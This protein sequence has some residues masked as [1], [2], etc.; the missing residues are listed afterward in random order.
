MFTVSESKKSRKQVKV[1]GT[2]QGVGF[3]PFIY[4]LAQRLKVLGW[5]QN[6]SDG[7][8]IEIEADENTLDSFIKAIKTDAPIAAEVDSIE[9]IELPSI[10]YTDF[11]I[12][13]SPAGTDTKTTIPPDMSICPDCLNDIT[14]PNN[15]RYAYPFTNCTNCGPRFTITKGI[16]YDRPQT[17]MAEFI[18][19][20]DCKAEYENP[21]DR[22]FHAQPNACPI[23]GPHL[24]LSGFDNTDDAQIT[25]KTAELLWAGKIIAIKGLGGYHLACDARNSEAVSTL[26]ERKGRIGKPFAIMCSDIEEVNSICEV[27]KEAEKLLNSIQHPIVLLPRKENSGISESCAPA[28]TKLGIM[29]P[30]TPMHHLLLKESPKS[31]VMTSGNLSEEPIAHIDEDAVKRLSHIADYILSHNRPIY[32][33]CDDSVVRIIDDKPLI[34]RRARGYVPQVIHLSKKL[35]QVLAL[36]S[37]LKN[38]FCITKDKNALISQHIGD[39]ENVSTIEHYKHNIDHF[40]KFFTAKPEVIACDMHPD[41]FSTKTAADFPNLPVVSVQHHHA[42]TASCMAENG[43]DGNVIGISFDGT[44]Y[45]TDGKIWGSEFMIAS[46]K[47]FERFAHLEYIPIP[48]GERAIKYPGRMALSY[49]LNTFGKDLTNI[50]IE[51]LTGLDES[52]ITAVEFQVNKAINAPFTSSMGRLFDSVSALLGI[53]REVTYEGQAAIELESIAIDVDDS[54]DYEIN[55]GKPSIISVSKMIEQI[56]EDLEKGV[57]KPYIAGKFHNTIANIVLNISIRIREATGLSSAVLSGGVFQNEI[58]LKH[59]SKLLEEKQFEVFIHSKVPTNDGGISLGQAVIA[60]N[61]YN[62]GKSCV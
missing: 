24:K 25:S 53:C 48:G 42:H 7:V 19:C 14:D 11:V 20:P 2:V 55:E 56:M 22:R 58:L 61:I 3:R 16:P 57:D 26:R 62:E 51:K 6:T 12:K 46:Y 45:G 33:P 5:V 15:R 9:T 49:L 32:V 47:E 4:Q 50:D 18:M 35:P 1:N 28:Q 40:C 52:E 37:D 21:L 31:L 17:T 41:Y 38:T 59:V 23:C 8:I 60:G 34:I 13:P 54:Y 29:L 30:Y 36:G 10:N 43:L 27:S 39:L 44:G